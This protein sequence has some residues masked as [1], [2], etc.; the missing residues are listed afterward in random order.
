MRLDRFTLRGQEAIQSAIE[1]AERNQHQQVEPEHVLLAM[2]EQPEGV[3]RPVLGKIGANVQVVINDL[4]AAI[5]RF[6]KV[7]GGQ[8][9]FSPRLSQIFTAAQKQAERMQD[10]Y[11]STEHLLLAVADERDG[12]AGRILRQHGVTAADLSKVIEQMRGGARVT[13]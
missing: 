1:A 13:D 11:I 2:L 8:Q 3:V 4:Q 10:E 5:A 12:A 9:Y 6:P 7:Q